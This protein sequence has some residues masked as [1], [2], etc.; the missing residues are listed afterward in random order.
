MSEANFGKRVPALLAFTSFLAVGGCNGCKG[1]LTYDDSPETQNG[2]V[3]SINTSGVTVGLTG[4]DAKLYAV[5]AYAGV[6]RSLE[7]PDIGSSK[8]KDWEIA[9]NNLPR[10]LQILGLQRAHG[11][12]SVRV[13]KSS[14]SASA[15]S[16][17]RLDLPPYPNG[18]R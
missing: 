14:G 3:T 4:N 1:P 13:G 10:N 12:G 9:A 15:L 16:F 6:W 2:A 11:N 8:G 5:T 18:S 7:N 17:R